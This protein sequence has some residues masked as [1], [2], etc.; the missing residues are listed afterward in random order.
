VPDSQMYW[1]VSLDFRA[2]A[3]DA[4]SRKK[5]NRKPEDVFTMLEPVNRF[6]FSIA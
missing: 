6:R 5:L 3:K 4:R 1:R 2:K